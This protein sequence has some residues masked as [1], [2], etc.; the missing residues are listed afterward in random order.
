MQY[1]ITQNS[2]YNNMKFFDNLTFGIQANAE[3]RF[4]D[5]LIK[6]IFNLS[7]FCVT[8]PSCQRQK[9]YTC[10]LRKKEKKIQSQKKNLKEMEAIN[11]TLL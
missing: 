7:N 11:Y 2:I 6:F 3:K 4:S 5:R 9:I 1:N 10:T 8:S